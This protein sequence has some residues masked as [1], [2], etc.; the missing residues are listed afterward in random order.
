VSDDRRLASPSKARPRAA[1]SVRSTTLSPG[2]TTHDA[3]A[4]SCNACRSR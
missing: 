4:R 1:T 3:R 2:R